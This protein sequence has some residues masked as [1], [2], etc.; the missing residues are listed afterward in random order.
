M[1][2]API[3]RPSLL[4]RIRD[5]RDGPSWSQ[6]VDLYAPLVYGFARKHGLQDADAADFT[7]EVMRAVAGNVGKFEYDPRRGSF[8]GW[9]F[10]VVRNRLRDFLASRGRHCQGSGD[11]GTHALLEQQQDP[12][13]VWDQEYEWQLLTWA[14]E[15]V[16]GTVQDAT[17]QA[18]W[19]TAVEGKGGQEV[20]K[21][22]GIS[23]AA[24]YLAK[25]RIM[26]RLKEL[27]EQ[28]EAD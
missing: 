28:V 13:D 18:F 22:L 19:Q 4:V 23:V 14:A 17:W 7:Q 15:Q 12:V 6:F 10:T 8:R 3:T 20:A 9:L 16:R 27:L 5:P 26:A 1:A 11:T 24:V 2:D 25:S 21:A